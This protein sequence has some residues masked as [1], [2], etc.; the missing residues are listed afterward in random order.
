[1]EDEEGSERS[2]GDENDDVME[3]LCQDKNKIDLTVINTNARSLCPKISSLIDCYNDMNA[4]V[5]VITETWLTDGES[6]EEEVEDL[7]LG[8]GLRMLYKNLSL[9]HI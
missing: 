7:T 5:G 3:E 2:I 9:I 6:L 8:T 1:M 4:S